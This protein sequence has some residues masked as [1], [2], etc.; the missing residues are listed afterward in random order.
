MYVKTFRYNKWTKIEV[1]W[2][3][4]NLRTYFLPYN[5][6]ILIFLSILTFIRIH[7]AS[8]MLH[9]LTLLACFPLCVL[10]LLE[11]NIVLTLMGWSET[12]DVLGGV[13]FPLKVT[14]NHFLDIL[15]LFSFEKQRAI[16]KLYLKTVQWQFTIVS[17]FNF[18]SDD[19]F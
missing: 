5:S 6:T 8:D 7:F 14:T 13:S 11:N 17:V 10:S 1:I 15:M 9:S 2:C 12:S 16:E 18:L 3:I 19:C 4:L